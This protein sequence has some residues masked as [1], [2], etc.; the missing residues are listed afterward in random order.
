MG[1]QEVVAH[2]GKKR[3]MQIIRMRSEYQFI[4]LHFKIYLKTEGWSCL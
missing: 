4:R 1:L 2:Q 3:K